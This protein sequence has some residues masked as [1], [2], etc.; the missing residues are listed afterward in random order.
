MKTVVDI[1]ILSYA[2]ND[3]LKKLTLDTVSTLSQSEDAGDIS[4]N[5]IVIESNKQIKPY[6]YPNTSTIYPR[7]KF[8]FNKYINIGLAKSH[9]QYVCICNNDLIFHKNW[10]SEIIKAFKA[11]KTLYSAS[12]YCAN[13]QGIRGIEKDSGLYYG[14]ELFKEISGW[15]FMVRRDIF[16]IIGKLDPNFKFW[17]SDND[18][19]NLLTKHNLKHALVS[20]S[21]VDHL[22]SQTISAENEVNRQ[23]LTTDEYIYYDYKWSHK[24]YWLY[25]YRKY[26]EIW[27]RAKN[28]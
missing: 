13:N 12:P 26:R 1:I 9:N 2:K 3:K 21:L 20:S 28:K 11:D 19:A 22:D 8:G 6:T 23:K 17:Y 25:I 14:Y 15:C 18:Y 24:K 4:F 10:A 5:V 7:S 27:K 16:D